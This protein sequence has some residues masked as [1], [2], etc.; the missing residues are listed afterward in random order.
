MVGPDPPPLMGGVV[1]GLSA[2]LFDAGNTL[3]YMPQSAEE[4][5]RDLCR[6]IGIP[7]SLDDARGAYLESERFY[8][9]HALGH[10]GDQGEFW[11][12][13]HGAALRNLRI[14]DPGGEKAAFLSHG[15]GLPGVWRAYPEAAAVCERL[16]S[17][18]LRLGV[19]SNGP[20]TVRDLLSQA[21]LLSFFDVV[22]TSQGVGVEKPDPRIFEA[23]LDTL[24]I[25]AGHAL[26]VGDLYEVDVL[27]ARSAG[28]KAA[29]IDRESAGQV[30]RDCV[31]L[32]SLDEVIPL[33]QEL[34]AISSQ[35]S[36][37]DDELIADG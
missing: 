28:L 7:V 20:V 35:P 5:L 6:Q 17:S 18:G 10:T 31:V 13:Y 19:V 27:G 2:V 9:E 21:G 14:D 8:S 15:F 25:Q 37:E 11:R 24:G 3:I 1:A 33:I 16:R 23:A 4:I 34:S 36:A 29:L 30:T 26:F 32:R 22:I 12:R